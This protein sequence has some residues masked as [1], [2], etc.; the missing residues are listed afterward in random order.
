MILVNVVGD[1]SITHW[2]E[3]TIAMIIP[4]KAITPIILRRMIPTYMFENDIIIEGKPEDYT[5]NS[6]SL[7]MNTSSKARY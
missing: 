7:F 4:K 2:V 5:V 1:R 3:K 6:F